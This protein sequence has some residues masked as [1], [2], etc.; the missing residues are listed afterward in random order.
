MNDSLLNHKDVQPTH[1]QLQRHTNWYTTKFCCVILA[2][3]RTLFHLA[4]LEAI[5]IRTQKPILRR[6]EEFI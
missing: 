1:R 5:F 4:A 6:Q 2:K 3:E